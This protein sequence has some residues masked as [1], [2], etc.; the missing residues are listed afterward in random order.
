[1]TNQPGGVAPKVYV[2]AGPTCVGKTAVSIGLARRLGTAILSADSRQCYA[3]MRI[4]TAQPTEEELKAVKHYFINEFPV[5]VSLTAGDYELLALKYL[6]E[7]FATNRY[8]VVCGGTGL[9]INALCG[10][11]DE[12]P[13][14]DTA[15]TKAAEEAYQQYGLAWLQEAVK[16]EDPAFYSQSETENPARLL[17][18]LAFVRT[19]G[20]SIL[21]YRT[22]VK[23]ERPF[24]I[25]KVGLE[26]P[27]EQL[28]DRINKRV[29]IMMEE[30]LLAEAE[31]FFPYRNLK[32][33]QTVGYAELFDYLGGKCSLHEAV[34]KIKQHTRNYAKR[35]MTWFRKDKEII[36][37]RADDPGLVGKI[38]D[39]K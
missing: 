22:Q 18:A 24:Q 26:L 6:D 15:I 20:K 27:R 25:V 34:D 35:Q 4:G 38:M 21:E 3:G 23:K 36:W 8:A 17:R 39:L 5:S 7:I 9:Y 14:T 33:L 32:N 28:Y 11:L 10:A 19:T 16:R 30:G 2:I 37:F 31:Q 12:M 1:M 29:D 13:A